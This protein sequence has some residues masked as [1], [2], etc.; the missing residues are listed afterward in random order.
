MNAKTIGITGAR[1]LLG[2]TLLTVLAR[3][4]HEIVPLASDIRDAAAFAEEVSR[5]D[6]DVII[7]TAALT[8]VRA[9]EEDPAAA[10]L[11]NVVGTRHVLAGAGERPVVFIS[12]ASVFSGETGG[13]VET[14]A[15][16]P[17]SEYDQT[18]AEAESYVRQHSAGIIIR[19]NIIGIHPSGSRGK[20][21]AEWLVDSFENDRDVVLFTDSRINPLSNWTLAEMI[22]HMLAK[23]VTTGTFH[24]GSEPPCSKAEIGQQ[25]LKH[26]PAYRGS[27]TLGSVDAVGIPR[28]KE[29]WLT[30]DYTSACLGITMP[31]IEDEI[32]RII[33][34]VP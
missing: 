11:V 17:R 31:A 18:K 15:P 23:D 30:C 21:F 1:G 3:A 33:Q 24:L 28:P 14:D 32:R 7:H 10:R 6:P 25:L 2:S 34:S 27:I 12:S 5:A 8:D 29:M 16:E 26:F 4:G 13:Y 20:N 22:G 19:T 9:C